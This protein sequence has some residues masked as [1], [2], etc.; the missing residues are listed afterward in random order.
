ME[1]IEGTYTINW[2]LFLRRPWQISNYHWPIKVSRA[3]FVGRELNIN[4]HFLFFGFLI[5]LHS[6][7][8]ENFAE[9]FNFDNIFFCIIFLL[10]NIVNC[11]SLSLF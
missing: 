11:V 6:L 4:H 8:F 5:Q 7:N 2:Q 9:H 10:G 1:I 3:H